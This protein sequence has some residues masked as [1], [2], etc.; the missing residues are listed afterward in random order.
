[1]LANL[2]PD[3][4]DLLI[5]T[6]GTSKIPLVYR[7]ICKLFPR[8]AISDKQ[9]MESVALGLAHTAKRVF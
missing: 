2:K 8:A 3:D 6:G 1:M 9:R 7:S 4:I 5:L